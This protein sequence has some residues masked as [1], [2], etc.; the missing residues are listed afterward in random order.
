MWE[1]Q[2]TGDV[3]KKYGLVDTR[4]G[5]EL[6]PQGVYRKIILKWILKT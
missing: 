6:E 2:E 4:E 3:H 1:V 5:E